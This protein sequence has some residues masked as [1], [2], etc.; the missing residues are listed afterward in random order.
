MNTPTHSDDDL[1]L[2]LHL[3]DLQESSG[4]SMT[5]FM[6]SFSDASS[7]PLPPPG[8]DLDDMSAPTGLF[9]AF[10]PRRTPSRQSTQTF[11]SSSDPI[12][13]LE[14]S[15]FG[16]ECVIGTRDI[17]RA[18]LTLFPPTTAETWLQPGT[19]WLDPTPILTNW[20]GQFETTPTTGRLHAHIYVEFAKRITFVQLRRLFSA[21]GLPPIN[22]KKSIRPGA[23]QRQCAINY[24]IDERKRTAETTEYVWPG[25]QEPLS[26]HQVGDHPHPVPE[27]APK[28]S[29]KENEKES[30][31]VWIESKPIW[32]SYDEIV[33]ECL[34]SK[35]LLATCSWGKRYHTGRHVETPRRIIKNVIL[36]YGAGG[37]GK[38][39]YCVNYDKDPDSVPQEPLNVRCFRRNADETKF[40]GGGSAA[41][42]GQRILHFEEFAG[43]ETF[44]LMK[45]FCDLEKEGPPIAIKGT[46]TFLNHDT[47]LISSNTHPA[48]WYRNMWSEDSKAFQPFW[49][50]VT[51]VLFFPSHRPDGS[52]N[53]PDD[54]HPVHFI[55]QTAEWQDMNGDYEVCK[56]HATK[57][58]P[59]REPKAMLFNPGTGG[60]HHIF[61]YSRTG[62][63][64][65]L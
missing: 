64:P 23:L 51:Q 44:S 14:E 19:Y 7:Q 56:R 42:R 50:R 18:I 17:R 46:G 3:E 33:H 49:R 9:P 47:V 59:L 55:D 1:S 28:R 38:S 58:W 34:E 57:Y 37:T 36:L 29:M 62:N 5:D 13:Q 45:T 48:G 26:Y 2:V 35:Q 12:V 31:R 21:A 25:N 16:Q 24:V 8:F 27:P 40:W 15:T 39:T 4:T 32:M 10:P 54:T 53:R 61:Q 22:V 65:T 60:E 63:D 6:E 52:A 43:G 30:Q 20:C 11:S 41:Y